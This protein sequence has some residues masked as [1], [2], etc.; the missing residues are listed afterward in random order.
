MS[1]PGSGTLLYTGDMSGSFNTDEMN[2]VKEDGYSV[3]CVFSGATSPVGVLK[4]QVS[5]NGSDWEDLS[6]ASYSV[7]AAGVASVVA[8]KKCQY[9]C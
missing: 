2:L 3:H 4:I 6:G 1:F 8:F 5:I 7:A 9:E